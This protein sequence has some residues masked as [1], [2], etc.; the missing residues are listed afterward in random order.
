CEIIANRL[1]ATLVNLRFVK[2]LDEE[3]VLKIAAKHKALVTVEENVVAG[4]VGSAIEELLAANGI[5]VPT[6]NL[7]IPDRFIEHGSREDCLT[8]AGLD[9]SSIENAVNHWWRAPA[10]AAGA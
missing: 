1:D 8:A 2:P 7:G 6:L 4:G 5:M 9:L 3:L 10:K